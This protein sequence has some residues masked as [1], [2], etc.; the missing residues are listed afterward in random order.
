M[1]LN[2]RNASRL[3][4]FLVDRLQ[5]SVRGISLEDSPGL[6]GPVASAGL[7]ELKLSARR[8]GPKLKTLRSKQEQV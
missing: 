4:A 6:S 7:N 3:D 2:V 5:I 1:C 8:A